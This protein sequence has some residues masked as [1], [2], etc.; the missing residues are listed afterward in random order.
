MYG[1]N[2]LWEACSGG[3]ERES[4]QPG[5]GGGEEEGDGKK[6]GGT[7]PPEPQSKAQ[8]LWAAFGKVRSTAGRL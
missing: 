4:A 6:G 1:C 3:F 7:P 2:L 8:K 5:Q